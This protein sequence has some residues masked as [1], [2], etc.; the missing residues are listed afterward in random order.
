MTVNIVWEYFYSS[1]FFFRL[2][3]NTHQKLYLSARPSHVCIHE[4]YKSKNF[5]FLMRFC[6]PD[7]FYSLIIFSYFKKMQDFLLHAI[8]LEYLKPWLKTNDWNFGIILTHNIIPCFISG[9][10]TVLYIR[11]A[12]RPW[13]ADKF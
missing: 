7:Y 9:S 10:Q 4:V 2:L 1:R 3:K 12:W 13:F 11:I 6:L 5:L 8:F